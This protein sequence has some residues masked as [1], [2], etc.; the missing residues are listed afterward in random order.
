MAASGVRVMVEAGIRVGGA[1][2]L[3][4]VAQHYVKEKLKDEL[5]KLG[6]AH[7]CPLKRADSQCLKDALERRVG[8]KDREVMALAKG[9]GFSVKQVTRG[10][11][12]VDLNTRLVVLQS[13]GNLTFITDY[14]QAETMVRDEF[15]FQSSIV[16]GNQVS[17]MLVSIAKAMGGQTLRDSGGVYWMPPERVDLWQQVG[18]AV[19]A[20]ASPNGKT[21]AIYVIRTIMDD[22]AVRAVYDAVFTEVSTDAERMAEEIDS[23]TLGEKALDNRANRLIALGKRVEHFEE[24]LGRNMDGLKQMLEEIKDNAAKGKLLAAAA[25]GPV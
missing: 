11:T 5:H 10:Q 16:T 14:L 17:S 1:V 13:A 18:K 8:G 22:E 2:T 21:G 15:D 23:L 3:W 20:S 24:L 9:Q 12:D 25:L 4:S 7:Y 6:L 19:E